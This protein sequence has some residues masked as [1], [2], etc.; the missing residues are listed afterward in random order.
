MQISNPILSQ[1]I[2]TTINRDQQANRFAVRPVTIEGQIVDDEKKK[3]TSAVTQDSSGNEASDTFVLENE[4]QHLLIRP[5]TESTQT[6]DASTIQKGLAENNANT[7]PTL[8]NTS[9]QSPADE[10]GFPFGN[11]RSL[12]GLA[13]SSLIIQNY[14][15]NTPEQFNRSSGSSTGIV[16]LF[17]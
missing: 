12:N 15:N 2:G 13:G 8:L 7:N 1:F 16:D 9:V 14:L 5:V 6:S 11:R 17:V 3:D 4:Q 10:Q